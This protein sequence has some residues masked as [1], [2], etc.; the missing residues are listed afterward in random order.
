MSFENWSISS[1]SS[2]SKS[3]EDMVFIDKEDIQQIK[4]AAPY[5]LNKDKVYTLQADMFTG[6][7]PK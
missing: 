7:K 2:E 5:V 4:I 1:E 6:W 3:S